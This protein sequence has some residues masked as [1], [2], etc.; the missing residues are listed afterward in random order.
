[1]PLPG[2]ERVRVRGIKADND[3]QSQE[4]EKGQ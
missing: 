3:E 4:K 1:M 2:W